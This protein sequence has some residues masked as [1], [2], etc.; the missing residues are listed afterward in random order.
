MDALKNAQTS[1]PEM[2]VNTGWVVTAFHNAFYQLL[3]APTAEEGIVNTVAQGGDTDT[4][5]AIAGA[6]LGAVHGRDSIPFFW[7][8]MVLSC[9]PHP[10]TRAEHPRPLCLWPTDLPILTE[11]LLICS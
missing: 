9:K 6:L 10:V 5:A 8:Q 11:Q 7:R 1:L 2:H 3:H 4:N